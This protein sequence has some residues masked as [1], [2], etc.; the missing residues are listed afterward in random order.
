MTNAAQS[1]AAGLPV[2]VGIDG[3]DAGA[4]A[5]LWA[6]EE[7]RRRGSVLQVAHA[8][9]V[10]T[11]PRGDP[12][13]VESTA[14]GRQLLADAIATLVDDFPELDVSPVLRDLTA[15]QLLI[16]LSAE[17]AL[18]VVGTR[19]RNRLAGLLLGSVSRSVAG[20]SRCPVVL[21]SERTVPNGATGDVVAGVSGSPAGRAAL[22]LACAEAALRGVAVRA[23]RS[24]AETDYTIEPYADL[25]L[26][27]EQWRR[28]QQALLDQCVAEAAET[29]PDVPIKPQLV[30]APA[31]LALVDAARD[32]ALLV[33]GCRRPDAAYLSRVGPVAS[34]LMHESP[35]PIALAGQTLQA[36]HKES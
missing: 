3:S 33:V 25:Q 10:T 26:D 32:A 15:A 7:A 8:G 1:T 13:D 35:V 2:L 22:Q 24:L 20:H 14:Y 29:Y 31:H 23:V 27:A 16:E 12:N 30:G 19:G 34:W 11:V 9:D 4:K 36:A 17:A 21:V 5:L 18:L 6:A 28:S